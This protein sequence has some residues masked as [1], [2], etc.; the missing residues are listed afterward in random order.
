MVK[1]GKAHTGSA[2]M[3]S[4]PD[5]LL[6]VYHLMSRLGQSSRNLLLDTCQEENEIAMHKVPTIRKRQ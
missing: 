2:K 4:R 5:R 6:R 3:V 1:C